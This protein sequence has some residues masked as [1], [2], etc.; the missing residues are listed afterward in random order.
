MPPCTERN[1]RILALHYSVH[2]KGPKTGESRAS[3]LYGTVPALRSRCSCA[4]REMYVLCPRQ[5]FMRGLCNILSSE[6]WFVGPL[7][8]A[9]S[10]S[11]PA[12]PAERTLSS[13]S[14]CTEARPYAQRGLQRSPVLARRVKRNAGN[15]ELPHSCVHHVYVGCVRGMCTAPDQSGLQRT[16]LEA[17]NS[18][19]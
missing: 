16:G 7:D 15:C 1:A 18:R 11:Q 12:I 13:H 19:N 14:V 8:G 6:C 4:Q 5:V 2:Y 3:A 10:P 17:F 9:T